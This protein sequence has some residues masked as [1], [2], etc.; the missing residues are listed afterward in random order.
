MRSSS[1][2]SRSWS[3]TTRRPATSPPFSSGTK[4]SCSRLTPKKASTSSITVSDS[5]CSLKRA[6][7][8]FLRDVVGLPLG[9]DVVGL[10]QFLGQGHHLQGL[11]EGLD[12]VDRQG[13]LLLLALQL[14]VARRR[15]CRSRWPASAGGTSWTGLSPSRIFCRMMFDSVRMRRATGLK[16][17]RPSSPGAVAAGAADR[18]LRRSALGAGAGFGGRRQLAS[19]VGPSSWRSLLVLARP[20]WW[21]SSWPWCPSPRA[22]GCARGCRSAWR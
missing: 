21:S 5:G 9:G 2:V 15:A 14:E 10:D 1:P 19:R 4:P 16:G 12:R 20:S 22:C 18:G 7:S 13:A 8:Q 11:G 6:S 3:M 17:L